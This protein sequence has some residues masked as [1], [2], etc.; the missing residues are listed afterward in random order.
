MELRMSKQRPDGGLPSSVECERLVLGAIQLEGAELF[1]KIQRSLVEQD[2]ILHKHQLIYSAMRRLYL[3]SKAI[4]RVTVATA[5][6]RSGDL[7]AVDGL[8]YLVSLDDGLPKIHNVEAYAEIIREKSLLRQTALTADAALKRITIDK[9]LSLDSISEI[10]GQF[11]T[12]ASTASADKSAGLQGLEQFIDTYPGGMSAFLDPTRRPK[13]VPTGFNRLDEWTGGLRP[14]EIFVLGG[15]TGSGKSAMAMNIA[16]QAAMR[17]GKKP[18]I[19][20]LE[21]SKE[22]VFTRM[23]CAEARVDATKYR[24]NYLNQDE[25]R[26]FAVAATDINESGIVVDDTS[27]ITLLDMKSKLQQMK[28]EGGVDLVVIDYLHL[29]RAVKKHNSRTEEIVELASGVWMLAQEFKIPII[30]VVQ[31]RKAPSGMKVQKPT[32]DDILDASKVG[33]D[34]TLCGFV[35][36]EEMWRSDRQDLQGM[37]TLILRKNRNGMSGEIPLVFLREYTK[38]EN[39]AHDIADDEPTLLKDYPREGNLLDDGADHE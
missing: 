34:S 1:C 26:R 39:R 11:L 12:L 28:A 6:M 31:I 17:H 8:S 37:A 10:A 20:S 15:H 16:L 25:R 33:H 27:G 14:G 30:E 24:L 4:D 2:F 38:F 21:M 29:M 13:G 35:W 9:D 32:I 18:A 22:Q 7:E 5:L 19:F 36:R 23:I 3:D